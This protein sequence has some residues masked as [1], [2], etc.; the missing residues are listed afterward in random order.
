MKCYGLSLSNF[1]SSLAVIR[2]WDFV[3]WLWSKPSL[4]SCDWKLLLFNAGQC[5]VLDWAPNWSWGS[6]LASATDLLYNSHFTSLSLFCP[7]HRCLFRLYA[8]SAGT[9]SYVSSACHKGGVLLAGP[10]RVYSNLS[11]NHEDG[12]LVASYLWNELVLLVQF[13]LTD[14]H[15]TQQSS[16]TLV[17]RGLYNRQ[18]PEQLSAESTWSLNYSPNL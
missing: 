11:N 13:L 15:I 4:V 5:G 12:W 16:V 7:F 3:V 6:V 18:S 8:L 17:A 2:L 10:G 9:V 1:S 14:I